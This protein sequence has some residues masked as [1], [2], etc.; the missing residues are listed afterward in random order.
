MGLTAFNLAR[1]KAAALAKVPEPEPV[2]AVEP[3]L[4][5]PAPKKRGKLPK[6]VNNGTRI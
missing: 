1:R 3:I 2:K 4:E 5:K 6:V